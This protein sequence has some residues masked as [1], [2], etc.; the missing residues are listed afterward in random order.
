MGRAAAAGREL[1]HLSVGHSHPEPQERHYVELRRIIAQP[2][3]K[4]GNSIPKQLIRTCEIPWLGGSST[5]LRHI[6]IDPRFRGVVSYRG[7]PL[8]VATIIPAVVEHEGIEGICLRLGT[9]EAGKPYGYDGA[10]EIATAAEE[11]KAQAIIERQ[12]LRW[13]RDDYQRIFKPFLKLTIKPPWQNLPADLNTEPYRDDAPELY[14]E[15]EKQILRQQIGA[16]A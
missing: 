16:T 11:R 3:F 14:R 6:Y 4:H 9:D 8:D 12:G 13:N 15:I 10:H 2:W 5:D 1:A 7:K